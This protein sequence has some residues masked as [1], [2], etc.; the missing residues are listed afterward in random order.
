MTL[1]LRDLFPLRAAPWLRRYK[2]NRG[3]WLFLTAAFC[4]DVGSGL[5]FFLLNLYLLDYHFN[6][7]AIG[8][9]NGALYLGLVVGTLPV[10]DL[11]AAHRRAASAHHVLHRGPRHR[12]VARILCLGAGRNRPGIP[13]RHRVVRLDRSAFFR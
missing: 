8:L 11:D 2:L 9:V 1:S 10:G 5:F 6:E 3:F 13:H 7:R 4:Y 12:R